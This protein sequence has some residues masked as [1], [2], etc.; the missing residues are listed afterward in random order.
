MGLGNALGSLAF[1]GMEKLIKLFSKK[2]E[3][4]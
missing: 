3:A 1:Y 2:E 4:I